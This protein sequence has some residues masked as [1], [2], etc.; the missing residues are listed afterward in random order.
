MT[1]IPLVWY[2][3]ER[4]VKIPYDLEGT[5]L[6][7][8][9]NS[10]AGSEDKIYVEIYDAH[11]TH[12]SAMGVILAQPVEYGL[13]SVSKK[14]HQNLNFVQ[15]QQNLYHRIAKNVAIILVCMA[16]LIS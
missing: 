9:T 8:R 14:W 16:K 1:P 10:A 13:G 15:F 5:P 12:I 4:D 11:D 3:V 6:Q 2:P 7:I